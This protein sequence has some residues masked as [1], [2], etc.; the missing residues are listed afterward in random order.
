M[1]LPL[2]VSLALAGALVALDAHSARTDTPRT[3]AKAALSAWGAA[4]IVF[5][6]FLWF[7][8]PSFPLHL[9]PMEGTVLQHAERAARL[10]DVYPE[11]SPEYVPLAYNVLYYYLAAPFI[12]A[13]GPSLTTLRLV[14]IAAMLFSGILVFRI[15]Q[16]HTRS[17]WWGF[18]ASSLFA[19][20][21][22]AM[23]SYL[24]TAHSDAWFLCSA[25]FGSYL[26]DINRSRWWTIAGVLMLVASFWFKQHGALF[27]IGGL[28]F[29]TLREGLAAWPYWL[30]ATITGPALYLLAG[31]A[32]FG[33][34]FH[35]FTWTVPSAWTQFRLSTLHRY[36]R[37]IFRHYPVLAI[38]AACSMVDVA[39]RGLR[40]LDI[41]QVQFLFAL[42]TGLLG[43]LDPEGNDNV[44]IPIGTWLILVG[45]IALHGLGVRRSG[46]RAQ[47]VQI[48]A[49]IVNFGLLAY[50][51]RD[52][53]VSN[54]ADASY[55]DFV[56]ML[57]TIPGTVYAPTQGQLAADYRFYPSAHW[58]AMEDMVRGPNRD[59]RNQP[60]TRHLLA[61]VAEPDHPAF[62]LTNLPLAQTPVLEFLTARYVLVSD[63]GDRFKPLKVLPMRWDNGWP[64]FMYRYVP[65][66]AR[67]DGQADDAKD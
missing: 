37:F 33:S 44:F 3:F 53:I 23:D 52:V 2:T 7:N 21:Y 4:N 39:R 66:G 5:V 30:V 13:F 47:H 19:A 36:A 48:A 56:G 41:W 27:A 22:R 46:S 42:L 55:A 57:N 63:F 64:R 14:S 24:D 61:P 54:Q 26:L 8:H 35:Y 65:H 38:A 9:E 28:A 58:V 34:H 15:V 31:P 25:L 45:S 11:P 10:A 59:R 51:P 18:M 50:D 20:A 49:L 29:L 67:S 62:I 43:A 6:V 17:A 1:L 16:Q 32:L 60:S 12:A 40:R